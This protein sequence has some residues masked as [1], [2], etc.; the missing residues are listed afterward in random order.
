MAVTASIHTL[1]DYLNQAAPVLSKIPGLPQ[2]MRA[3]RNSYDVLAEKYPDAV[4]TLMVMNNLFHHDCEFSEI[5]QQAFI[6]IV[7]EADIPSVRRR[8]DLCMDA[9]W[10]KHLWDD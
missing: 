1:Q 3:D 8:Y 4:F 7:S 5:H 2:L 6:S 9:Y 10:Q